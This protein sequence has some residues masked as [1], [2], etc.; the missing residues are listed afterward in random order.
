MQQNMFRGGHTTA[1][2]RVTVVATLAASLFLADGT[3]RAGSTSIWTNYTAV[4]IGTKSSPNAT[5]TGG[6]ISTTSD[7][8]GTAFASGS[9]TGNT[10]T[11]G[12]DLPSNYPVSSYSLTV[13]GNISAGVNVNE[14]SVL[15]GGT[16]SGTINVNEHGASVVPDTGNTIP[17]LATTLYNQV[18]SAEQ[19]FTN[20]ANSGTVTLSGG[21]TYNLDYSG[22]GVAV[23]TLTAAE[24]ATSNLNLNLSAFAN[25]A[26]SVVINVVGLSSGFN[27]GNTNFE[28]EFAATEASKILWNFETYSSTISTSREFYGSILAPD[29]VLTNGNAIDGSVW[30]Q[31]INANGE[32]HYADGNTLVQYNGFD[33]IA[34]SVPEPSS[35]VLA[36]L[37]VMGIGAFVLRRRASL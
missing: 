21:N 28:G 26:T 1:L 19:A 24:L 34:Q 5:P 4:A 2:T 22:H 27:F 7:I 3:A 10:F 36:G 32:I 20:M 30:V 25:G 35:I 17:G 18:M 37:G 16:V 14:G 29:A 11:L 23:F 13:A 8:T 6:N 12:Q 31:S 33:P 9:V 15:V